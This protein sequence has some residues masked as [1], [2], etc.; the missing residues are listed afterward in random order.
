MEPNLKRKIRVILQTV[1]KI[2]R[3]DNV[4][5]R[6]S[7]VTRSFFDEK[8]AGWDAS[9]SPQ[10][11]ARLY[12]IFKT[13]IPKLNG[14]IL[15][16]G[17]GTGILIDV[18]GRNGYA[19]EQLIECDISGRMLQIGRRKAN[20][21]KNITFTQSDGHH[22]S[23][24]DNAFGSVVCFAVF[25]HFHD[26]RIVLNEIRRVL[27]PGGSLIILHLMGHRELN[28]MHREAGRA[29]ENDRIVPVEQLSRIITD[30]G[31]SVSHAEEKK[32]LFL[33]TARNR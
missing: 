32:D 20:K 23:F 2:D 26:K 29:V 22:L 1:K 3:K 5:K 31:F 15:D 12:Q 13:K 30:A 4:T 24:H 33:I 14:P 17:C 6:I 16:L 27:I 19:G 18:F 8:A 9:I 25:P 10:N 21:Y 28:A 7:P 11:K